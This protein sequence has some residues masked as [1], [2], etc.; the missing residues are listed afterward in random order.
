MCLF[1]LGHPASARGAKDR[2]ETLRLELE[3]QL[4]LDQIEVARSRAQSI[5]LD[6]LA[7]ELSG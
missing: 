7:G 1:V 4:G 2:A 6:S 3:A 5:T